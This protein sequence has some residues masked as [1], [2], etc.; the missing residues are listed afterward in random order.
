MTRTIHNATLTPERTARAGA[1]GMLYGLAGGIS[2]VLVAAL[3]LAFP[4][5]F[6]AWFLVGLMV[7][8]FLLAIMAHGPREDGQ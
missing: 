8:P 2:I 7:L 3:I 6:L 4:K 5:V 1:Y